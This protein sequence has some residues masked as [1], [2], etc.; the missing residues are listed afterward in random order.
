MRKNGYQPYTGKPP[1]V[2]VG[3][4]FVIYSDNLGG[5]S[6]PC[7]LTSRAA[8]F[9]IQIESE[10]FL[11]NPFVFILPN[12]RLREMTRIVKIFE[13]PENQRPAM[14]ESWHEWQS[15]ASST[16]VCHGTREPGTTSAE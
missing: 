7:R 13:Q 1:D 3:A 9:A 12:S 14:M 8:H 2:V 10:F 16:G 5:V 6:L 11:A 4:M 15:V